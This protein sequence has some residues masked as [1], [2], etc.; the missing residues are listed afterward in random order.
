MDL[1]IAGV[2]GML[3]GF[4]T[5]TWG[6]YKD[7]IHEGYSYPRYFRSVVISTLAGPLIQYLARFDLSRAASFVALFGLIYVTERAVVELYKT[8]FREEDQSKYFIPMRFHVMGRIVHSRPIRWAVG[9]LCI[10]IAAAIVWGLYRIEQSRPGIAPALLVALVGSAGGWVSALSGAWKDA[11]L[12]GFETLKF[13]RSPLISLTYALLL[14]LLIDN[15]LQIGLAS[16]G[17]TIATIETYKTFFF[18]SKP[19]GKF[20]GKP[21]LYPH[22]LKVRQRFIPLYASIWLLVIT[23]WVIAFTQPRQGLL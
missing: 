12:E 17:Y 18:P 7:A 2:W 16:L 10:L 13:F 21:I 8:F 15:Y 14:A 11:P 22:M 5:A 20:A 6:I 3:A 23:A 4:H 1:F 9:T 19:R